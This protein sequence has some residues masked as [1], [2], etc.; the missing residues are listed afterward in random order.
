MSGKKSPNVG[1]AFVYPD[2]DGAAAARKKELLNETVRPLVPSETNTVAQLLKAMQ[3]MSIQARN[4]GQCY[5]VMERL[6]AD[7]DRP[8]VFLGLAGPLVA[9]GLR[10]V[11]PHGIA[12]DGQRAFVEPPCG[13]KV[14]GVGAQ[15]VD[16]VGMLSLAPVSKLNTPSVTWKSGE[17]S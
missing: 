6:Y 14:G 13:R 16:H 3:G 15:M 11:I 4:V 2:L 9:G 12:Q 5:E 10:Q 8:T 1:F 17:D 7:P